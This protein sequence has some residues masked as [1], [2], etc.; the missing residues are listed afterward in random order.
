MRHCVASYTTLCERRS[1]AIF[2]IRLK[3]IVGNS[4]PM[5]TVQ[6]NLRVN[7]IVQAKWKFNAPLKPRARRI[8]EKWAKHEGLTINE[9]L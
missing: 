4:E 8:M 1:S 7:R 9:H 5:G 3:D 2:T 6:V